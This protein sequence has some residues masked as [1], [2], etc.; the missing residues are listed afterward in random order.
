MTTPQWALER[1]Q[2]AKFTQSVSLDLSRETPEVLDPLTEVPNEIL[3]LSQL[4]VLNLRGNHLQHLH[5]SFNKFHNLQTLDLSFNL[6][7]ELPRPITTLLNLEILDLSENQIID[8]LEDIVNLQNLRV[9]YLIRNRLIN[10]PISLTRLHNLTTLNLLGNR[11]DSLPE[12][13]SDMQNLMKLGLSKNQFTKIPSHIVNLQ[14]LESLELEDNPL[15]TPPIEIAKRGIKSIREYFRQIGEQGHDQLYE[16]KLLILGEGGAGKTT[17]SK[18]IENSDYVLQEEKSTEGVDVTKWSFPIGDGNNFRVNI[19]DFGGQEIYHSTHQFFLTKRSLYAL[20]ADTRKEDTDFY[21]WLNVVELLSENSPLLIIKNEKQ[22]RHRDLNERQLRGQFENLKEVLSV[23]LS[24]NRGLGKVLSEI[25]H[26]VKNLPH[27]GSPLPRTWVRVREILENDKRN[28]ISFEEYLEICKENGFVIIKDSLQ[29]SDYLNDIGVF[30]H[31]Q[32]EP[33]LRKTVILKPKWGTD[34]VYKVLDNKTVIKNLGRFTKT[35]LDFIWNMPDYENMRD[36]LLQLM[37]KF[38]LCYEIPFQNGSYIA[39]QLLTENQP[40]Y[41]LYEGEKLLLRYSY[42]FMPKGILLQF[43]VAMSEFIWQQ[44]VWKSGVVIEKD[45]TRAEIIEYYGKREIQIQISG[46]HKKD[47]MTIVIHELDKIHNTYK[48]LRFDKKIPC[49]CTKCK[50]SNEPHFYP[51]EILQKF[52]EDRRDKI[53]CIYSYDMVSVRDLIDDIIELNYRAED[54]EEEDALV[55]QNIYNINNS[56]VGNIV[57]GGSIENSINKIS[58]ADISYE[59]KQTLSQL[60]QSVTAMNNKLGEEQRN[61][62]NDDLTQLVD[63]ATKAVPNKRRY[64][65]SAEGLIK[66]AENLGKIGKPVIKLAVRV[67]ALLASTRV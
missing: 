51:F 7:S 47:L 45:K 56:H 1:I 29:L 21:Y 37:M 10:L 27:I 42:E 31:F 40:E 36:E 49:N 6:F 34:A 66:A 43:I 11:L 55:T 62:V 48:R 13:I 52:I 17:L 44:I 39:P 24:N 25:E 18:K 20:V 23:N 26:Y 59:L 46:L 57:T 14:N 61:K 53:Q 16:A 15:T 32:D 63:Q 54:W 5:N 28:Y 65:V 3:E 2:K 35:D 60:I 8:I 9:L 67:L 41:K 50:I 33:L 19:W 58:S 4:V 22:D 12:E 64:S 38:K 30:L